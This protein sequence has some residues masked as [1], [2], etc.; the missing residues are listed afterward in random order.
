MEDLVTSPTYTLVNEYSGRMPVYHMDLYRLS[1]S[2][3]FL[4]MG[5]EEYF[6]SEGVCLI[7]WSER[8]EDLLPQRTISISLD[9]E[10]DGRRI[11]IDGLEELRA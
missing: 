8:I 4:A 2:Y 7:E 5:G 3:E 1:G 9:F 10:E 6:T 11:I